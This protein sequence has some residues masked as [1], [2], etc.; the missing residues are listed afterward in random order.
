MR[1]AALNYRQPGGF[2]RQS[3]FKPIVIARPEG[4]WQSTRLTGLPRPFVPRNDGGSLWASI[5]DL[6]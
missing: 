5:V 1:I 6:L 2:V 4:P 3:P